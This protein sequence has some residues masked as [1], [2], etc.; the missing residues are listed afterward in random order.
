M[1]ITGSDRFFFAEQGYTAY[2]VEH[3][4][5]VPAGQP[6][7]PGGGLTVK[8]L[9]GADLRWDLTE[10]TPERI[11]AAKRS[12]GGLGGSCAVCLSAASR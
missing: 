1:D 10:A 3:I 7:M 4:R 12:P 9:C 11:E 5:L 6:V 8:A 2:S